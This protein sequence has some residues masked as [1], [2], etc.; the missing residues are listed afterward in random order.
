MTFETPM[1]RIACACGF[2]A[3]GEDETNNYDAFDEHPCPNRAR[4]APDRW[5]DAVFSFW[6]FAVVSAVGF[7]I[8]LIVEVSRSVG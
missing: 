4:P 1:P 5:Y 8:A 3:I 2:E 6:G 7:A